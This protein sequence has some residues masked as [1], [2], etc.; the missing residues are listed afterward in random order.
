MCNKITLMS[1][2]FYRNL[3]ANDITFLPEG[4]FDNLINLK[5]LWVN[6]SLFSLSNKLKRLSPKEPRSAGSYWEKGLK[7]SNSEDKFLYCCQ[8]LLYVLLKAVIFNRTQVICG[9]ICA[10]FKVISQFF[11]CTYLL[12]NYREHLKNWGF[13]IWSDFWRKVKRPFNWQTG[14]SEQYFGKAF[15]VSS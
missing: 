6:T 3:E 9:V 5:W 12:W 1:R 15:L 8:I 4:L 2:C 11:Y 13:P 14:T 7:T 10:L